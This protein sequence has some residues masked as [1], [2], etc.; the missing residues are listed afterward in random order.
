MKTEFNLSKK[1]FLDCIPPTDC[2][3]AIS[4]DDVKEFIKRLKDFVLNSHNTYDVIGRSVIADEID[5]LAG[6]KLK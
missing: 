4:T 5:I 2:N 1:I 6:E 3:T